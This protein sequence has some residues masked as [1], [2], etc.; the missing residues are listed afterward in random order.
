[1]FRSLVEI[2]YDDGS[3]LTLMFEAFAFMEELRQTTFGFKALSF[4]VDV[5]YAPQVPTFIGRNTVFQSLRGGST[6]LDRKSA[7]VKC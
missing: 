3:N 6:R 5:L 7:F 1:M 4:V 2:P